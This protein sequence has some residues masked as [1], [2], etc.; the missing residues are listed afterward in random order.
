MGVNLLRSMVV[1]ASVALCLTWGASLV[2]ADDGPPMGDLKRP[3]L[4]AVITDNDNDLVTSRPNHP[5]LCP[6]VQTRCPPIQT[7][8]PAVVTRCPPAETRCP[9]VLTACPPVETRCPP[10]ATKCPPAATRCPTVQTQCP[11]A[12][13]QCPAVTTEL[14]HALLLDED[15]VMSMSSL[16][17]TESR[18]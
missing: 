3:V 8:C 18:T 16:Q 10:S 4:V 7:Q 6:V 9:L 5:T 1:V 15:P 2:R 14:N 17:K 12:Q 11:P 13:T